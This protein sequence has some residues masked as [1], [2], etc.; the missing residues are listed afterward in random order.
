MSKQIRLNKTNVQ[1]AE[2]P[3]GKTGSFFLWDSECPGF[4]LRI[5]PT[6]KKVFVL[7]Y[8]FRGRLRFLTLGQFGQSTVEQARKEARD[9]F[10]ILSTGKDPAKVKAEEE[11]AKENTILNLCSEYLRWA[12]TNKKPKSVYDD[13]LRI[14]I[15][16]IPLWGDK[17]AASIRRLDVEKFHQQIGQTH[18][19]EAN[20]VLSLLSKMFSL[21]QEWGFI[22]ESAANP[23]KRIKRFREHKRQRWV[24]PEEMPGLLER[25]QAEKSVYLRAALLL[26]LLTGLRNRELVRLKWADL[27]LTRGLIHLGDNKASRPVYLPVSE[28]ALEIFRDL[29]RMADNPFVFP[30]RH[31]AESL[32]VFPRQAWDRVRQRN[33]IDPETKAPLP[34]GP[35]ADVR[36]H[37][38][39]RTFGS[40]LT[41]AGDNLA[42]V[43]RALNQST[44]A[45]TQ[46]YAHLADDP[47][48]QAV[49]RHGEKILSILDLKKEK[50]AAIK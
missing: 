46:T 16:I 15:K 28:A 36:I 21:A 10:L 23:A 30:G 37:D 4:G 45:V 3:A 17:P 5:H 27:D 48:K 6:G 9:R 42:I 1:E 40:W 8:R 20:R 32:R 34:D 26:Y 7:R 31:K 44:L 43:A 39:R 33:Q 11:P 29:P 12:E 13:R 41:T 14:N 19:Y 49:G 50:K 35:L 18:P 22:P 24:L 47:L 38:L 2:Y 25:I